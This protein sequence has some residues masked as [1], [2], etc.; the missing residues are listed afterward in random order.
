MSL[1]LGCIL[2]GLGCFSADL[3]WLAGEHR[4]VPSP[5]LVRMTSSRIGGLSCERVGSSVCMCVRAYVCVC[6]CASVHVLPV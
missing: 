2:S 5:V 6:V 4:W 3:W 1:E